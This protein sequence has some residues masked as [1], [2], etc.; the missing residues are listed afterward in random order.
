MKEISATITSKGQVNIP[1]EVRRHLGLKQGDKIAF[2]L[3]DEGTVELKAPKYSSVASLAGAAGC[4]PQPRDFDEM[5]EIA[6]QDA[7]EH[8]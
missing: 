4:L 3:A 1:A 5:L 2:V 8:D 6:R 7:L